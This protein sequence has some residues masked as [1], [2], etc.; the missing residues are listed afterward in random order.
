MRSKIRIENPLP[1][2]SPWTSRNRAA[3]YV[4]D[5]RAVYVGEDAIRFVVCD[6]R[7]EAAARNAAGSFDSRPNS[8]VGRHFMQRLDSGHVTHA[9]RGVRGSE[10]NHA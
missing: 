10:V 9:L 2:S 7:N 1:G 6:P 3:C 5:R 4:R 8:R